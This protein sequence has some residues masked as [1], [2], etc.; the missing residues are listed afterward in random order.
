MRRVSVRNVKAPSSIKSKGLMDSKKSFGKSSFDQPRR[1][2]AWGRIKKRRSDDCTVDVTLDSGISLTH[3][4]VRS[5]EW[6]TTDSTEGIGER[7]LPP[8]DSLV[9]IVFPYGTLEDSLVLCSAFTLFGIHTKKQQSNILKSGKET[10]RYRKT[11][12]GIILTEDK[13]NG[14]LK[15]ELPSGATFEISA[16]NA[17]IEINASGGVKITPASGA[18]FEVSVNNA[19]IEINT[20]GGVK[21]TPA[22]GQSITLNNGTTGANDYLNCLFAGAPHCLDP[23]SSVKVP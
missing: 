17:K 5:S 16:N 9:L 7:D 14:N 18:T 2:F 6:A 22:S 19:K 10:E 12:S 23:T 8:V 11:E 3:V 21:I 13:S 4:N 1:Y 20:S 15:L